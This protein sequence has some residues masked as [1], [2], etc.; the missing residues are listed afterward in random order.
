MSLHPPIVAILLAAG[1]GTRFGGG[2]LLHP[3][4][5]GVALAAHAARN[6]Q[7]ADLDVIA[8]VRTGDFPL[9]DMLEE[10]GCH[11]FPCAEAVRGMGHSLAHGVNAAKDAPGW[12]VALADMPRVQ[13]STIR[14][15]ADAIREG[16][17]IAAPTYRSERG[18]PVGFAAALRSELLALSGDSG[19][20]AVLERHRDAV[21]LIEC[22]DP[23]IA[24]DIDAKTDLGRVG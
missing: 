2:K 11:V 15:I 21:R 22:D 7:A 4:S 16:A 3:L 18:H 17:L 20:R 10:E 9:A 5:D 24:L 12:V 14:C 1:A 13:P 19:A 23:G 6:L 8:V